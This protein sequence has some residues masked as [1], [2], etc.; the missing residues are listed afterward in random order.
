MESKDGTDA[1]QRSCQTFGTLARR[2]RHR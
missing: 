2:R 1:L